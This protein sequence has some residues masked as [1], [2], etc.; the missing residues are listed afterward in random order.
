MDVAKDLTL[1]TVTTGNTSVSTSGLTV[2]GGTNGA[3]AVTNTGLNNGGNTITNVASG[4]NDTDAVNVAQLKNLSSD[5]NSQM[6]NMFN[7]LSQDV[8]RVGA[9]AAALSA[10]KPI[11]YDSD[12]KLQ[13]MVGY[14]NYMGQSAIAMG[15]AY[16]PNEDV[17]VNAGTTLNSG[18]HMWNA[19]VSFKLGKGNDSSHRETSSYHNDVLAKSVNNLT[20]ENAELKSA[21]SK[22]QE[23]NEKMKE[24]NSKM[25]AE[26]AYLMSKMK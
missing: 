9:N 3:V 13:A 24:S 26:I 7:T 22:M 17:M 5:T 16:T 10:L 12:Q 8:G 6:N 11:Q 15:I 14:G 23:D 4:V 19:G 2:A 18:S 25:Q 1:N 21:M 20:K